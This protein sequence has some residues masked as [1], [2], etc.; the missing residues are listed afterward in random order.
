MNHQLTPTDL[1][2]FESDTI[3]ASS[4]KESKKLLLHSTIAPES[5]YVKTCVQVIVKDIVIL[6]TLSLKEAIEEYNKH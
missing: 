5:K 2:G 3:L 1:S 4:T 6:E